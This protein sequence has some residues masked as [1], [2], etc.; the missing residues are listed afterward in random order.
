MKSQRIKEIEIE[1]LTTSHDI[2]PNKKQNI[3]EKPKPE[4]PPSIEREPEQEWLS[5]LE[6]R[7]I[8][9]ESPQ[10][11]IEEIAEE[12]IF[13]T[14]YLPR[15]KE[16]YEPTNNQ[17]KLFQKTKLV[18]EIDDWWYTKYRTIAQKLRNV[19]SLRGFMSYLQDTILVIKKVK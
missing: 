17:E 4:R 16:N 9:Q 2:W 3:K 11:P 13:Y 5:E 18:S 8:E 19:T 12:S 15:L 10:K 14:T 6:K 7:I 1:L